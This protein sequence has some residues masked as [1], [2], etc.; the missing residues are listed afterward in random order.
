MPTEGLLDGKKILVIG[1]SSGL[2]AAF[3]KAAV[4]QAALVAVSARREDRLDE[5]VAEMGSGF[6]VPGDAT[7]PDDATRVAGLAAELMGGIDL[8]FYVAGYGV[9]Q[10]IGETNPDAVSYT[11]LTLPTK[12]I[13]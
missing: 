11:H 10:P 4:S 12:R 1:A 5:L 8:M 7:L 9:L 6:A 13:V 2:G 3:A